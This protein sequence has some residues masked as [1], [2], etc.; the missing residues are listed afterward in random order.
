MT[1]YTWPDGTPKSQGNAFDWRG[2]PS[3]WAKPTPG[4]KVALAQAG[5]P[6]TPGKPITIYSRAKAKVAK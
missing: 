4:E 6:T 2:K 1:R 3:P 5:K